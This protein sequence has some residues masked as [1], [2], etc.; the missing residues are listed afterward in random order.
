MRRS[1]LPL[2]PISLPLG[3]TLGAALVTAIRADRP[4]PP[5][6][7]SMMDGIAFRSAG[8]S[9]GE[10]LDIAGLHAAGDPPPDALPTAHAW[11]IMTGAP[12]PE[13][14]DTIVPYEDLH[15]EMGGAKR[16]RLPSSF[17]PGRFIHRAGSDSD[18]G[19]ILVKPGTVIG[20]PEIAI[21]AS[22]GLTELEVTRKPRIAILTTGDE[23]VA[24][25]TTPEPWQIRRSNGAALAASLTVNGLE[26]VFHHHAPDDETE[27]GKLLDLALA[28][29][30]L[31]VISGGIS[32]GK[33]DFIRPL[34]EARLGPPTFHGVKQRPG[35]PLAFWPGPPAVFALP[36]NPVSVLTTYAR[37]VRPAISLLCG[38]PIMEALHTA[39]P[40]LSPLQD[41]TYLMPFSQPGNLALPPPNSGNFT[42]ISGA[43]GILEIPPA[44]GFTAG[45]RLRYYPFT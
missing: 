6:S 7:R 18:S 19:D 30:D 1:L 29:A 17:V 32:K 41:F 2:A 36:G 25:G 35:K 3:E 27:L 20:V 22:V 28:S 38:V 15:W 44:S 31:L 40:G 21:A 43:T 14:C 39:P 16:V 11:E 12:V 26:I 5:Y 23:A 8:L 45:M 37:Y 13:D 24:P 42:S 33:R 34:L 9:G 10:M 4:L